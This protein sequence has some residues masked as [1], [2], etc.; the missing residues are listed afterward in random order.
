MFALVRY[1]EE[2]EERKKEKEKD[3][4]KELPA[5]DGKDIGKVLK[6]VFAGKCERVPA[7]R[8]AA[9]E[10]TAWLY[11]VGQSH[12]YERWDLGQ[13]SKKLRRLVL[14]FHPDKNLEET[15]KVAA[16]AWTNVIGR[17][18]S[19]M[20]ALQ[21]MSADK[22]EQVYVSAKWSAWAELSEEDKE[23]E[24]QW[25]HCTSSLL[26]KREVTSL[27]APFRTADR[28]FDALVETLCP[29][30]KKH[31]K[32]EEE[33]KEEEE[34]EE[35]DE[36]DASLWLIYEA[37]QMLEGFRKQMDKCVAG[38]T[39]QLHMGRLL[40]HAHS[41][42]CAVVGWVTVQVLTSRVNGLKGG[43]VETEKEERK[44]QSDTL[45]RMVTVKRNRL[46]AHRPKCGH[47]A[48]DKYGS[49]LGSFADSP[50]E[51]A[52]AAVLVPEA[53]RHVCGAGKAFDTTK[54]TTKDTTELDKVFRNVEKRAKR[55]LAIALDDGLSSISN[56]EKGA[57]RKSLD[58]FRKKQIGVMLDH[59]K[60][61]FPA[62]FEV[63]ATPKKSVKCKRKRSAEAQTKQHD[64][65][66]VEIGGTDG[67]KAVEAEQ[68]RPE[69]LPEWASHRELEQQ[70]FDVDQQ[71]MLECTDE[72]R[73]EWPGA[74]AGF[75]EESK[76]SEES[77]LV[78][79][80]TDDV[81]AP[82][83]S[84]TTLD[85][86]CW[87]VPSTSSPEPPPTRCIPQ[88]A[89][90][91]LLPP[92]VASVMECDAKDVQEAKGDDGEW[93]RAQEPK[94]KRKRRRCDSLHGEEQPR[95]KRKRSISQDTLRKTEIKIS[96]KHP[97]GE[98]T[99][100]DVNEGPDAHHNG[101]PE[102]RRPRSRNT[103]RARERERRQRKTEEE[104]VLFVAI[105]FC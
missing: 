50:Y 31:T 42:V 18:R 93:L 54:H 37:R 44:R 38:E 15:K 16:E 91:T 76:E 20:S 85:E 88:A 59:I 80:C 34:E 64:R 4:R 77:E 6:S 67:V 46:P 81:L 43:H 36:E 39:C 53:C 56:A 74:H 79:D 2:E 9:C 83:A 94:S 5:K 61:M 90:D 29:E 98:I 22:R 96:G 41:K 21:E 101:R 49:T 28:F 72:K 70:A 48:L 97:K 52:L 11:A 32:S 45:A 27:E 78:M 66:D 65:S 30:L 104:K 17:V 55:A 33:E 51:N 23:K 71:S 7:L 14:Q 19:W 57:L 73:K 24:T 68:A 13:G 47:E 63:A 3:S 10:A 89:E 75:C 86:D 105:F 8:S 95:I 82:A 25:M 40:K 99:N 58:D 60:Q 69:S 84:M 103:K 12:D 35:D 26:G 100:V 102:K 87:V 1:G 92:A 62:A